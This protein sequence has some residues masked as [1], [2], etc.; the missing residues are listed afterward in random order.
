MS[1]SV[2]RDFTRGPLFKPMLLF[3]IPFM[4]S[5]AFQVFYSMT[6]MIIV[7][8]YIGKQGIAAVMSGGFMVMFLMI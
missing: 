6:D 1:K 5:N 4:L 3:S 8:H 2:I 7:G